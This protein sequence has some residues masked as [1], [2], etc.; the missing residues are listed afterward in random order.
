MQTKTGRLAATPFEN[1]IS[2][3][4]KI[5]FGTVVLGDDGMSALMVTPRKRS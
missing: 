5:Q 1:S 3:L 2:R 4:P